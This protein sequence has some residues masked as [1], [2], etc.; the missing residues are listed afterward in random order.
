MTT[1]KMFMGLRR[2]QGFDSLIGEEVRIDQPV[3]IIYKLDFFFLLIYE[4]SHKY[5]KRR[6]KSF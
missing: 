2:G 6:H 3:G 4:T 1:P 5:Y